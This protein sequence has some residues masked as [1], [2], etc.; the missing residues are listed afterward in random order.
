MATLTDRPKAKPPAPPRRPV[1]PRKPPQRPGP[2]EAPR[3][4]GAPNRRRDRILASLYLFGPAAAFVL[5]GAAM[6]AIAVVLAVG[7]SSSEVPPATGAAELVPG[8]ALL[9][10]HVSTDTSRPA[11]RRALALSRRLP[12]SA[13]LFA[14]VTTRVD[15]MLG[16]SPNSGVSFS[17]GV[18]PWLGQEAALAVLDTSGASAGS[19]IVLDVRD[20]AAARRFLANEGAG[21][22][23]IYRHVAL[24]SRPSG[25]VLAFLRHYLVLGQLA[26]VR[27]AID[28]AAGR[29]PS[30]SASQ[31]YA[32]AAGSEPADRVLDVYASAAGIRRALL[33]RSG[34]LGDLGALLDHPALSAAAIS[35]AAL[36]HGLRIDV[37]RTLDP[38]LVKATEPVQ[39]T[40]SLANTL[41]A[42]STLLLDVKGLRSSVP[43]LLA[44]GAKAGVAARI[45]PLLSR[46]GSALA[47]EGVSLRRVLSIF[48]GETAIAI[49]PGSAGGGPAPVIVTRSSDQARTRDTL[50]GLEG[51][52]T[53]VF[54]PPSSGPGQVPEV[55][56][57]VVAG[58]PVHELS[59]APGFGLAYAVAR[60][61]VAVSTSPAGIA[62]VFAH[63][64][65]LGEMPSFRRVLG[66][67]PGQVTSLVFFDLSQLLRL[68]S[69]LGLIGGT[70]QTALSLALEKIRAVGVATWRGATDTTTELLLQ[71]P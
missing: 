23:G 21:P 27:A 60:G 25:T 51:P 33:P 26:S 43:G 45:A 7:L 14:G 55:T 24:F 5:A 22:D 65:A 38:K 36:P 18:R 48:S 56:D 6:V 35:V 30:L 49:V 46:L 19:L 15:A 47:A 61:L 59:L 70:R 67:N 54:A 53:Q 50:A 34:L 57:T 40:P 9:Y 71:I 11:V 17:A 39:F 37:H 41:P 62:G 13:A 64:R 16:A 3:P 29:T 32:Q 66:N 1:K 58:V 8:N 10:L 68:G 42:G 63:P 4:L 69:R 52:L 12:G 28:V 44:L 2:D 20:R 31:G